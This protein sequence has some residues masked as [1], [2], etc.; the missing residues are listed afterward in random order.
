MSLEPLTPHDDV[1]LSAMMATVATLWAIGFAAYVFI[2]GYYFTKPKE[3]QR[4][5]TRAL[6]NL[7]VYVG[8][9][10]MGI[11]AFVSI[12]ESFDVLVSGDRAGLPSA[13]FYFLVTLGGYALL[14]SFETITSIIAAACNFRN[15]L[16]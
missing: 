10:I 14:F 5:R 6:Q 13:Q 4:D 15:R 12:A 8:Y 7:A 3:Q 9:L 2:A 11:I 1:V 16:A